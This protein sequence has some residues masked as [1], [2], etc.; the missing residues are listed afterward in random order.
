MKRDKELLRALL[1]YMEVGIKPAQRLQLDYSHF[2]ATRAEVD[3][4]LR[5]LSQAG[6]IVGPLVQNVPVVEEM[7]WA[8]HE[9]LDELRK[10]HVDAYKALFNS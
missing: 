8:G 6:Y 9:Y 2:K 7:T 10:A 4:H 1:E 3:Y 5:L